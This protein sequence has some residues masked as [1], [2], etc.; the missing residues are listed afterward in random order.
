MDF[1][2]VFVPSLNV[3]SAGMQTHQRPYLVSYQC[4]G[5][6]LSQIRSP[7]SDKNPNSPTR[8]SFYPDL[9]ITATKSY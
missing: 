2:P 5:S 6:K 8:K 7:S 3:A 9:D 4:I 1:V